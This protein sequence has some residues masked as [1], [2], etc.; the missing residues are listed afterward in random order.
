MI[1][2]RSI[3]PQEVVALWSRLEELVSEERKPEL[4]IWEKLQKAKGDL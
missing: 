3:F 4:D 2:V 1:Y